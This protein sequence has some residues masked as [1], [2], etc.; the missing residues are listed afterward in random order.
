M[1]QLEVISTHDGSHSIFSTIFQ[2]AYHSKY[3]AVQESVHV[4]IKSGLVPALQAFPTVN[5]LEIGFG[6]GLNVLLTFAE[7]SKL[8]APAV[9]V[10]TIEGFP[11]SMDVV[12]LLDYTNWVPLNIS[13]MDLHTLPWNQRHCL[14]PNFSFKKVLSRFENYQPEKDF[15]Q[16]IYFDPFDPVSQPVAWEMPF[17]Q[18]MHHALSPGGSL[19]TYCAKGS[20]KRSFKSIG[21][22]VESL[23]GPPGK[24]EMVR[25]T[26]I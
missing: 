18:K 21:F 9:F 13:L 5:V 12:K 6:T 16:L 10:E 4:F 17:L 19:V 1:K 26:K 14:A 23:P 22:L 24:R 3:G 7:W 8:S 11:L 2:S 25:C 20:V 15:F